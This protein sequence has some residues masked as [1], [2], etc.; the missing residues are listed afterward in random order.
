[1]DDTPRTN[2]VVVLMLSDLQSGTQEVVHADH[3][4]QLERENAELREDA[5]RYRWLRDESLRVDPV[6]AVVVKRF[7]DRTSAEWVN[8][9]ML[10]AAIDAARK[11]E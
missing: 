3:A 2:A 10:D 8:V 5:E 4:R 1:M 6:A 9:A 7:N 11:V